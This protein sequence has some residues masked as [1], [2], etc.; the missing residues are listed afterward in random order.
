[1][2]DAEIHFVK[3]VLV[4]IPIYLLWGWVLYRS[5]STLWEAIRYPFTRDARSC[6]HFR[7]GEDLW[8]VFKINLWLWGPFVLLQFIEL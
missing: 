8:A 1:M 3:L 6:L 5:W 7:D 2:T 4:G